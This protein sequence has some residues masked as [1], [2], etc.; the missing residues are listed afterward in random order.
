[1]GPVTEVARA[2]RSRIPG[3][4]H[5]S[6]LGI[7]PLDAGADPARPPNAGLRRDLVCPDPF[8][9]ALQCETAQMDGKE[10][11]RPWPLAPEAGHGPPP[12]PG[13]LG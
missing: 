10:C 11:E 6:T 9:I 8:G 1:M 4:R 3:S 2:I 5:R 7:A 12:R 13:S